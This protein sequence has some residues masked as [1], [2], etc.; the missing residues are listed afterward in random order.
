MDWQRGYITELREQ[1]H[2]IKR[3]LDRKIAA[4]KED[5]AALLEGA[6]EDIDKEILTLQKRIDENT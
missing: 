4:G 2:E 5:E 3:K 1:R 6:I